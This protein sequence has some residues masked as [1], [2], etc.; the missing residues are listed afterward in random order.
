VN[1]TLM[2]EYNSY[3]DGGR[4]PI[5]GWQPDVVIADRAYIVI[6][7]DAPMPRLASLEIDLFDRDTLTA[8][9]VTLEGAPVQPF[10]PLSILVRE[11]IPVEIG[12]YITGFYPPLT[13][14][15]VIQE[16]I[17][18]VPFEWEMRT[19]PIQSE[20]QALLHLTTE[21]D[22]TPLHTADFAPLGGLIPAKYWQMNDDLSDQAVMELPTD[23]P[24]GT[25][26]LR[27]GLYDPET[28]QRIPG[29]LQ[30]TDTVERGDPEWEE[31]SDWI[32]ATLTWD[33]TTWH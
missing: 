26:V 13:E 23:L 27:L 1:N 29:M 22:A 18:T 10:R 16:N 4:A 32:I 25:Y 12:E 20:A 5:T 19:N 9:P 28:L 21:E 11:T 30:P 7:P 2:G 24:A 14:A 33:G 31:T 15:P 3:P 6:S 17:V 8:L